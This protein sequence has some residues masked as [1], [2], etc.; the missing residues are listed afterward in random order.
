MWVPAHIDIENKKR[1]SSQTST[2]EKERVDFCIKL[3]KS[4]GW[5]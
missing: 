5:A 3:S 4:E 2:E 1:Q